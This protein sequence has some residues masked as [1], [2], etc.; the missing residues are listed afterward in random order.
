MFRFRSCVPDDEWD[1][2][3]HIA[4]HKYGMGYD[5]NGMTQVIRGSVQE[6][7]EIVRL[8]GDGELVSVPGC[9]LNAPYP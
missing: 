3:L 7:H 8:N 5:K 2:C 4:Q 6:G 9:T 1:L